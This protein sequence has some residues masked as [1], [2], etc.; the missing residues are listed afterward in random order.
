MEDKWKE[1][2]KSL[3]KSR[4][5][6]K[7]YHLA[8]SN[9]LRRKI[10]KLIS[11]GKKEG[12]IRDELNLS[13][14]ELEFHLKFLEHGFCIERDGDNIQLTKEGEIIFYVDDTK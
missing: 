2:S 3:E 6:H 4:E 10:L 1:Y 14:R 7:R 5:Y 13:E 9:P 12:E 11:E 8:V